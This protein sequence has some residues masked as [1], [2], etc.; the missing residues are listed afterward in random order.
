VKAGKRKPEIQTYRCRSCKKYQQN[1][2]KNLAYHK[3]TNQSVARLLIEGIGIRGIARI[4][5]ISI[6]TV[7]A[8]I[9]QI[10]GL[11]HKTYTSIKSGVYEIDELWTFIGKKE[12]EIWV[13]YAIERKSKQVVD[14]SVG[15]RTR[16]NLERV[17][18]STL[19]TSPKVICTD[20][21]ITYKNLIP[22]WLHHTRRMGTRH[23]ERFN[24][25]LRMHLKRLS[26]KT[27]CFS[28]SK[29]C[30]KHA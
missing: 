4:L 2:Y 30:W 16:A 15:S 11:I 23:I 19:Q 24:L 29:E 18:T 22:T 26:R 5:K 27:I 6:T 9:K 28:R 17:T 14:F 25:N 13:M 21:L 8:R 20:R 7:I 3:D 1:H 10:A 12:N